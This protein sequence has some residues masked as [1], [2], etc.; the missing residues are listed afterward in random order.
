MDARLL[1]PFE[2]QL[3]N[4]MEVLS[5]LQVVTFGMLHHPLVAMGCMLLNIPGVQQAEVISQA[6][7]VAVTGKRLFSSIQATWNLLE[8]S[9]GES[10]TKYTKHPTCQV[11]LKVSRHSKDERSVI[12]CS[13]CLHAAGITGSWRHLSTIATTTAAAPHNSSK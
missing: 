4:F 6:L 10:G 1:D 9:A 8:Q 12:V 2:S 13:G 11:Y 7:Q 5:S 3:I